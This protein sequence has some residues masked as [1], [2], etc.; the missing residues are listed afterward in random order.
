MIVQPDRV[1]I[2]A[3]Q[4]AAND[5]PGVCAMSG[6]PAETWKKFSFTTPPSWVYALLILVCAGGLGIVLFAVINYVVSQKAA[7]HLPLTRA[8]KRTV[9]LVVWVAAGLAI[10]WLVA[11]IAAAAIAFTTTDEGLTTIAVILFWLGLL[12]VVAA[13]V[14]RQVVSR[15]VLP[16]ARVFEPQPGY[17]DKVVELRNLHP[18]F[19]QAVQHLQAS[20]LAQSTGST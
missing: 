13:V 20:R 1:Q 19:V 14:V 16:Q 6:Q 18:N 11:W 3:S 17:L 12:L 5:F 10:A 4:L 9:D 7:G 8:S 15:L 2:W